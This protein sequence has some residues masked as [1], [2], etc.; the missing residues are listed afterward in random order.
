[1][2]LFIAEKLCLIPHVSCLTVG[3]LEGAVTRAE[4]EI[5]E[6]G[7]FGTPSLPSR[8]IVAKKTS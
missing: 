1:V 8:F 7:V 2:P 4:F 6:A 5:V 3:E